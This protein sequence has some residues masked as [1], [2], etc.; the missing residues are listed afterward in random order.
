MGILEPAAIRLML[1]L[2]RCLSKLLGVQLIC[3]FSCF[4]HELQL[5]EHHVGTY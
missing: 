4:S 1:Q 2:E 5:H 3:K